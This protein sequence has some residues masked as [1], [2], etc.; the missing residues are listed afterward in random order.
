MSDEDYLDRVDVQSNG[1]I[2]NSKGRLIGKLVDD[3]DFNSEHL[4]PYDGDVMTVNEKTI[5]LYREEKETLERELYHLSGA[6]LTVCGA[7]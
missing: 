4:D 6:V 7:E 2:R 3:V 5:D 1:L